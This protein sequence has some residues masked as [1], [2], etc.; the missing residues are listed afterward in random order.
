MKR[1][2]GNEFAPF[3][4]WTDEHDSVTITGADGSHVY[5]LN[6]HTQ[7]PLSDVAGLKAELKAAEAFAAFTVQ[8]LNNEAER[9]ANVKPH[10][11]FK[12]LMERTHAQALALYIE[13]VRSV[14]RRCPSLDSYIDAMGM[15]FFNDRDGNALADEELPDTAQAFLRDFADDFY[16]CF[17][18]QG[19]WIYRDKIV[20]E[21]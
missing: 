3:H 15:Q 4:S 19:I 8:A 18:S 20:T 21:W 7:T 17:K 16:D 12:S 13:G 6:T 9:Y 10:L 2:P 11:A 1:V 14:L 5:S